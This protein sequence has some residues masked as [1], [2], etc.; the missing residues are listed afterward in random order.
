MRV[1]F[2]SPAPGFFDMHKDKWLIFAV[3]CLAV[4]A[5]ESFNLYKTV[6]KHNKP[7]GTKIEE[8]SKNVVGQDSHPAKSQSPKKEEQRQDSQ[9]A[10]RQTV[11]TPASSVSELPKT[12]GKEPPAPKKVKA[13]QVKFTYSDS[14]ASEVTFHGSWSGR[15]YQMSSKGGVWEFKAMLMPGEYAYHFR[16]DGV[17]KVNPGPVNAA[18]DNIIK[19]SPAE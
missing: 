1:R 16:A 6:T 13:V 7:V 5:M 9:S 8:S 15:S 12:Q 3:M 4:F 17:K 2:P 14:N 10:A 19:V 11:Q 18:G